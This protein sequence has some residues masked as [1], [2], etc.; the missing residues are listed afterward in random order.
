MD[1][2]PGS[3][4]SS[5]IGL[6]GYYNP[7]LLTYVTA[8]DLFLATTF[9]LSD[10]RQPQNGG[11]FAA[12]PGMGFA[13]VK[14]LGS[15]ATD[16]RWTAALGNRLIGLGLGLG[17][18]G[19]SAGLFDP[20][21]LVTWGLLLRPV[22]QL[23]LGAFGHL[24]LSLERWAAAADLAWRPF[25]REFLTLFGDFR[26]DGAPS[27]I[28]W[29]AGFGV[30]VEPLRGIE[31]A[32]SYLPV[33][34]SLSVGIRLALGQLSPSVRLH[35]GG[36]EETMSIGLRA[37]LREAGV[38]SE[39]S[40]PGGRYLVVP[41]TGTIGT[42]PESLLGAGPSLV[43][44]L[45]WFDEIREDPRISGLVVNTSGMVAQREML[46]ELRQKLEQLKEAGK[47][48]V[49]YLESAGLDTYHFASVADHIVLDPL[50]SIQIK[51][52]VSGRTF[53]KSALAS[54]G[55]G[56]EEWRL[57]RYKSA[58]ENLSREQMSEAD[59]SQ[60]E[61]LIED[62]YELA[63]R[64]VTGARGLREGE[65]DRLVDDVTFF[66]PSKALEEG[67]ADSL[68]RW[69]ELEE[70]LA[71]ID[72]SFRRIIRARE[73][74]LFRK[75]WHEGWGV[76]PK[77]A[78]VYAEGVCAMDTGMRARSLG[79]LLRETL[80]DPAIRA[81][82]LRVDSP[83]GDPVASEVVARAIESAGK[84]VIV[85]Q[86][87]VAASGGY[88]ISVSGGT[89][90]AAPNTVTGSIGVI[91]G[92]LYDK[93]LKERAGLSTDRVQ[94]GEHADVGF[95]L[96]LP[97][98]GTVLPDRNLTEGERA[99]TD[100]QIRYLYRRFIENV[101]VS[102]SIGT[103]RVEELAQGR[104]W[105]G[106]RALE[107]GLIDRLGG[108]EEAI[109]LARRA[110]GIPEEDEIE[111]VELPALPLVST[112]LFSGLLPLGAGSRELSTPLAYIRLL[113]SHNGEP[114]LLTPLD[115]MELVSE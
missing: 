76:P 77:I 36:E 37:G 33:S 113:W 115:Y 103:E 60:R 24:S 106:K 107:N 67:L 39:L 2:L 87:T 114:L 91:S 54:I 18:S 85:S 31:A 104:I 34:Q 82:V 21:N 7:A 70:T 93:G 100:D 83:G 64:D 109:L 74:Q 4:G 22:A 41:L 10:P 27:G 29:D 92:W 12:I 96:S 75:P 46:W 94:T 19:E 49:V 35:L 71:R 66:S 65:F 81:V 78:L 14:D 95:G 17:W 16:L 88:W 62:L 30:V 43:T 69:D 26:I 72:P 57:Y 110:A 52:F 50:G 8:P 79:V 38:L 98:L 28:S 32:L 63:R 90:V 42:R 97:F 111:I 3:P 61:A 40:A 23:S 25:G 53:F 44:L 102:R 6:Y 58:V 73:R 11:L 15:G 47:R 99:R 112:D 5:G 101:S 20:G 59:R 13:A 48:I 45:R 68:G 86:G 9:P 80:Q 55:V 89:I 56:F 84:P 108:L 1:F 105:S 51:G